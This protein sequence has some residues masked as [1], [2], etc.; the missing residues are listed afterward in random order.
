M[1]KDAAIVLSALLGLVSFLSFVM[2]RT[3]EKL[4]VYSVPLFFTPAHVGGTLAG[5]AY[6]YPKHE[7]TPGEIDPAMTKEV[8]CNPTFR[9]TSVRPPTAYTNK[10][11]LAQLKLYGY[12][13]VTPL[14]Y[15]EDHLVSIELG[16]SATSSRNLWPQPY[17]TTAMVA[18]A[19]QKDTVE[20]YLHKQVC[21]G[22]MSL[23]AAQ[24][25]VANDWYAVYLQISAKA[26]SMLDS[27]DYYDGED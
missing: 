21:T 22:A 10:L 23:A 25:Y 8:I 18:G 13:D 27:S 15:E 16:G 9:T 12:T 26:G 17:A 5:P 24:L 11:K 14:D 1:K 4:A 20:N 19:K 7:L 3:E 6:L 2:H